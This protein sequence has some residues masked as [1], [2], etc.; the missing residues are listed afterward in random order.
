MDSGFLFR[1]TGGASASA[2]PGRNYKLLPTLAKNMPQAYF[3]N[4]SSPTTPQGEAYD[5][6]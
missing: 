1:V 4:A 6:R 2:Y 3:L 5:L